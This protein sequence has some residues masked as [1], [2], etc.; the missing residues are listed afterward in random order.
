MIYR[1]NVSDMIHHGWVDQKTIQKIERFHL[2]FLNDMAELI[3]GIVGYRSREYEIAMGRTGD[4]QHTFSGMGAVD[5]STRYP[6][7]L[8]SQLMRSPYKRIAYYP[9]DRFFHCDYNANVQ[10]LYLST[11]DSRWSRIDI[12]SLTALINT[13]SKKE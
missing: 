8:L 6:D 9:D 1:F 12:Y 13:R 4:S 3:T 7:R 11:Q 2:P 10:T 5:I